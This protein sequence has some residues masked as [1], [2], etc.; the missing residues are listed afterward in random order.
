[1]EAYLPSGSIAHYLDDFIIIISP[2]FTGFLAP[3]STFNTVFSFLSDE[4]GI[5]Q[6]PSK[7]AA[8]TV[9]SVL[10]IEIDSERF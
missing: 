3:L 9:V 8:G 5:P 1:L 6:N 10:G 7:D 2:P 4:L